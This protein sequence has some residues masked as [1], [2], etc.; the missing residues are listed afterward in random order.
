MVK[1]KNVNDFLLNRLTELHIRWIVGRN[2]YATLLSWKV[3]QGGWGQGSTQLPLVIW[4]S[5]GICRGPAQPDS[6]SSLIWNDNDKVNLLIWI[7]FLHLM[8]IKVEQGE[9]RKVIGSTKLGVNHCAN[10]E[11]KSKSTECIQN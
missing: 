2:V 8:E 9:G 10:Q 3:K 11:L 4:G 1:L 6:W 5:H 7:H